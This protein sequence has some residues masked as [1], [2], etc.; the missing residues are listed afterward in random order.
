LQ[1]TLPTNLQALAGPIAG[2]AQGFVGTV[3]QN[4]LA[5][6]RVQDAFV[7]AASRSQQ[8]LVSD[9][10]GAIRKRSRRRTATSSSTCGHSS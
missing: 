6:P 9:L 8:Q 3:A 7:E 1:S 10:H 4:L 5:R 2:L